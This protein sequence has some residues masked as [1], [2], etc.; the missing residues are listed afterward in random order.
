MMKMMM[1]VLSKI[2]LSADGVEPLEWRMVVKYDEDD[3]ALVLK[4]P[5]RSVCVCVKYENWIISI[6]LHR[7]QMAAT[8]IMIN[9]LPSL[10]I[11]T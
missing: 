7:S 5:V 11:I 10:I 4:L 9:Y 2:L 6:H 8:S 3:D 1:Q